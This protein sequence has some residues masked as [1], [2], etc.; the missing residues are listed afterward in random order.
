MSLTSISPIFRL[1]SK[2][3]LTTLIRVVS[4][5]KW[6]ILSVSLSWNSYALVADI[7]GASCSKTIYYGAETSIT[8]GIGFLWPRVTYRWMT[9][10]GTYKN[11]KT[12]IEICIFEGN[13]WE[14]SVFSSNQKFEILLKSAFKSEWSKNLSLVLVK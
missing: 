9:E 11:N 1:R 10:K 2:V 14:K 12:H 4:F 13:I 7:F 6:N 8:L 3:K 5:W